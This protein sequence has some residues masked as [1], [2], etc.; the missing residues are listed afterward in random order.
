MHAMDA[1]D[2]SLEVYTKESYPA[3]YE[4][5]LN[6]KAN[7]FQSLLETN[8]TI[9][10]ETYAYKQFFIGYTFLK[11]SMAD[12]NPTFAENAIKAFKEALRVY[13]P[14]TNAVYYA[15]ASN[16]LGVAYLILSDTQDRE[17]NL[18]R[19]IEAYQNALQVYDLKNYPAEY[20]AAHMG[21]GTAFGSLSDFK[22]RESNLRKALQST[23]EALKVFN[24]DQ[25]LSRELQSRIER[26]QNKLAQ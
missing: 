2:K 17:S 8:D 1:Y 25:D 22:E 23:R 5:V 13:S 24:V 18:E 9:I 10:D 19:A 4:R 3:D 16:A 6:Q 14:Q 11:A 20:G 15:S 21:L 12:G 26:D 7:A